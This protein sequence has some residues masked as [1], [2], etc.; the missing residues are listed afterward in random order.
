MDANAN[1]LS[2]HIS[3]SVLDRLRAKRLKEMEEGEMEDA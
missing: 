2:W 1:P 3:P